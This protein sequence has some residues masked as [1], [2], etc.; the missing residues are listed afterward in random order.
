AVVL[1][2]AFRRAR[3]K[4]DTDLVAPTPIAP[5]G[6]EDEPSPVD[7]TTVTPA[8]TTPEPVVPDTVA[9]AAEEP[10]LVDADDAPVLV[11]DPAT[12]AAGDDWTTD[13]DWA[14]DGE[15]DVEFPIADYD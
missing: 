6:A 11:D 15:F 9:P 4:A 7:A 2:L 3:P 13:A 1:Y 10:E 5:D 14:D 8:A 12:S